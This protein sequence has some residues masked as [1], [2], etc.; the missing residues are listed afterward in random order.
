MHGGEGYERFKALE[1]TNDESTLRPW[2]SIRYVEM[3]A[4]L[5]WGEL[6]A[7]FVLNEVAEDRCLALEFAGLVA[8]LHPVEDGIFLVLLRQ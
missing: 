2:T 4:I 7:R 1:L 6:G 8:W 5:L 3:I